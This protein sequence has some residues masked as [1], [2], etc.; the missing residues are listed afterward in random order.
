MWPSSLPPGRPKILQHR[1]GSAPVW[2]DVTAEIKRSWSS[3]N[4]RDAWV[5]WWRRVHLHFTFIRH[6]DQTPTWRYLDGSQFFLEKQHKAI[7]FF[8]PPLWP[9]WPRIPFS[10]APCN[11]I[12]NSFSCISSLAEE[13]GHQQPSGQH[14]HTAA[15]GTRTPARCFRIHITRHQFRTKELISDWRVFMF[16]NVITCLE[17]HSAARGFIWASVTAAGCIHLHHRRADRSIFSCSSQTS[18][19]FCSRCQELFVVLLQRWV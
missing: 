3:P 12:S 5:K 15:A 17:K 19:S 1:Y 8:L 4:C 6:E 2:M 18:S 16:M 14:K 13:A 9:M 10:D 11:L 7:C